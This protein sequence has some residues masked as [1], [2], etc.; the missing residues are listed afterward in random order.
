MANQSVFGKGNNA[1]SVAERMASAQNGIPV[2]TN[3]I[4]KSSSAISG[5]L[6]DAG[7]PTIAEMLLHGVS[8]S[9]KLFFLSSKNFF[10]VFFIDYLFIN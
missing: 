8:V 2:K 4:L 5:N 9:L 10:I 6:A 3:G 1:A 7:P